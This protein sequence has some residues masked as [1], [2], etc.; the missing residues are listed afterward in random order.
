MRKKLAI[1]FNV[2]TILAMLA[3]LGGT[4]ALAAPAERPLNAIVTITYTSTDVPKAIPDSPTPGVY[5]NI[6]VPAGIVLDVNMT[7]GNLTHTWDS[8]LDI[9][10]D[11][12]DGTR[13][14]VSTDNGG[15]G[16]NYI[17]TVFDDEAVAS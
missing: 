12:P 9:F 13:V 16:D 8:D 5:S 14:E 2:F 17:N 15:S 6:V 3:G 10:L 11:H 4:P 7:I 1:W